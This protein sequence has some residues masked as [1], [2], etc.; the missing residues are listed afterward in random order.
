MNR[1]QRRAAMRNEKRRR[2]MLSQSNAPMQIRHGHDGKNVVMQFSRPTDN[3]CMS[4]AQARALIESV[5]G[6]ITMLEAHIAQQQNPARPVEGLAMA[7]N[8]VPAAAQEPAAA[9]VSE[10]AGG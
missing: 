3:V 10:S 2:N 5:Q 9:P 4:P 1:T 7:A 8:D 6:A